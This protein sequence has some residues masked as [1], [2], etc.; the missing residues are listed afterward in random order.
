MADHAPRE[1]TGTK[2]VGE[3]HLQHS[4][5]SLSGED[6]IRGGVGGKIAGGKSGKPPDK[7]VGLPGVMRESRGI[8]N[9]EKNK[10]NKQRLNVECNR[11]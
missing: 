5:I 2:A 3:N 8:E 7:P 11:V 1:E 10:K 9:A 6:V 4:V